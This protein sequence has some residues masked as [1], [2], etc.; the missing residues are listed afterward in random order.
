MRFSALACDYDGTLA[1]ADRIGPEAL[2]ALE[3]ARQAR[4]RLILV[5]GRTFFDPYVSSEDWEPEK[6]TGLSSQVGLEPQQ[7]P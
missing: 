2:G 3:R 4:L 7:K 1:F 6:R 5:T